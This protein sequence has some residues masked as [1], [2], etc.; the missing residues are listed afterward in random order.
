LYGIKQSWAQNGYKGFSDFALRKTLYSFMEF[1][2][3]CS[4]IALP[5]NETL[6]YRGESF[7]DGILC[8]VGN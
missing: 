1:Q 4:I 7:P 2:N 6:L 8:Q 3:G 5:S